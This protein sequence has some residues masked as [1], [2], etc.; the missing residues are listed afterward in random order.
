MRTSLYATSINLLV[1]AMFV[2]TGVACKNDSFKGSGGAKPAP[3]P[4]NQVLASPPL[5]RPLETFTAGGAQNSAPVDVIFAMDTSGSMKP[6]QQKLVNGMQNLV[7]KFLSAAGNGVDYQIFMIGTGF[8]FPTNVPQ[9]KV[10]MVNVY[11]DSHNALDITSGFL[12]GRYPTNLQLRPAANKELVIITDD[13][14]YKVDANAFRSLVSPLMS[15]PGKLHVHGII[16]L[17]ATGGGILGGILGAPGECNIPNA[18]AQ[19]Q[20]LANDPQFKGLIQDVCA[21]DWGPLIDNLALKVIE[22]RQQ[23]KYPLTLGKPKNMQGIVVKVNGNA[24]P[25]GQFNYLEAENAIVFPDASAPAIGS[26]I[27][28]AY[29]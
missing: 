18:G 21:P 15:N 17:R 9:G 3:V 29:D 10:G 23:T 13:E 11:I 28:V 26:S 27:E 4:Q 19:Y 5:S 1:I 12:L 16:G 25:A 2:L 20:A 14:A 7:N 6:K 22:N 8:Q 24:V